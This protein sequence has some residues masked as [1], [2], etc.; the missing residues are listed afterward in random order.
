M[1]RFFLVFAAILAGG[2]LTANQSEAGGVHIAVGVGG[3]V[4]IP[5][6]VAGTGG[7]ATGTIIEILGCELLG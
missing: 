1:R 3:P 4:G 6:G 5:I 7:V 2:F